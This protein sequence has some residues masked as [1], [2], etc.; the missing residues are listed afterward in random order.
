MSF[1]GDAEDADDQGLELTAAVDKVEAEEREQEQENDEEGADAD[2][3]DDFQSAWEILDLAR[4]IYEKREDMD[5]EATL[6]L[7]E[8]Y[9]YLGDVSLE[10]GEEH[11]RLR[12]SEL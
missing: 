11:R 12:I 3:D 9:I 2:P 1:S 8:T 10:T 6:R 4:A 5:D 7:A